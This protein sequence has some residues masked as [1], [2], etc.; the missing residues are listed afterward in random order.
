MLSLSAYAKDSSF[1][2]LSP[3]LTEIMYAIGAS[4]QLKAVSDRCTYPKDT[5]KK[6]KIGSLYIIN[7]EL[8]LK[9]RPDY[10]LGPDTSEFM[11]AKYKKINIKPL[12]YKYLNIDAIYKNIIELGKL[13]NKEQNALNVVN[14]MKNKIQK[15][16]EQNKKPLKIFYV[17]QEKPLITIG[18]K[19]FIT[20]VIEQSGNISATSNLNTFYPVISEEYVIKQNPDIIIVDNHCTISDRLKTLF[21][22]TKIIK[23]SSEQ[24]DIIDRPCPRIYKSVEFFV[25]INN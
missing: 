16:K 24:S 3:A 1:V 13:A 22:N 17:I 25:N 4:D 21:P 7:E 2:S 12:C 15:A 23:L 14:D 10:I 20:D 5:N 6:P 11:L 18:K 8:L 19:S 9:I